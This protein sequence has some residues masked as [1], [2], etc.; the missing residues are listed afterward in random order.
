MPPVP[1]N[2][3]LG[4]KNKNPGLLNALFMPE[5]VKKWMKIKQKGIIFGVK[6]VVSRPKW[7]GLKL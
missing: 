5:K 7:S 1:I 6:M 3:K 4:E 2:K